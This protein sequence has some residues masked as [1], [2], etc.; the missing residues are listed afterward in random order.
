MGSDGAEPLALHFRGL[1]HD[2]QRHGH[3][4]VMDWRL[5]AKKLHVHMGTGLT[6]SCGY[7]GATLKTKV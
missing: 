4:L 5:E 7:S 6:A 1:P 2:A 3:G